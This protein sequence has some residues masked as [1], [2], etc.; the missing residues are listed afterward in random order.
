M[1]ELTPLELQSVCG[2]I[3]AEPPR[4]RPTLRLLILA[5]LRRIFDPRPRPA[6]IPPDR[7]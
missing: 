7:T 4:P 6:P 1:R 5:I 3:Q 2:G